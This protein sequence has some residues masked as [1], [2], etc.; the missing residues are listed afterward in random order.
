MPDPDTNG[1][2]HLSDRIG[3]D[4]I[5]FSADSFI[6]RS[7]VASQYLTI[8]VTAIQLAQEEII[9]DLPVP[10]FQSYVLDS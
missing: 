5:L 2:N 10:M 8:S 9:E 1:Q 6:P 3:F 7:R 4:G